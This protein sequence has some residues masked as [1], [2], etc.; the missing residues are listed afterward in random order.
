[1]YFTSALLPVF[2]LLSLTVAAPLEERGKNVI[3]GYRN[4]NKVSTLA[5]TVFFT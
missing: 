2:A 5:A 4:L 1:M 3:I